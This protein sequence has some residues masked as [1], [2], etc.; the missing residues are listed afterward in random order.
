MK[1]EEIRLSAWAVMTRYYGQINSLNNSGPRLLGAEQSK[2]QVLWV[3]VDGSS[4]IEDNFSLVPRGSISFFVS[5]LFFSWR[6][7][8]FLTSS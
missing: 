6:T 8:A 4:W 3:L 7:H 2:T 5:V 1:S